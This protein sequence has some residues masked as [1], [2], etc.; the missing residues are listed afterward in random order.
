MTS[1]ANAN[2][3][4]LSICEAPSHHAQNSHHLLQLQTTPKKALAWIFQHS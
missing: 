3:G 4:I 2:H 1:Q